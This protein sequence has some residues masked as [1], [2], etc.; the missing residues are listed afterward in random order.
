MS[1]LFDEFNKILKKDLFPL[2]EKYF[3]EP[4]NKISDNLNEFLNDPR[5]FITD[6]FSKFS[7]KTDIDISKENE[8]DIE[9]ITD[10]DASFDDEYDDLLKRLTAIEENMIQIEKILMDKN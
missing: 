7:K 3:K 1:E 5:I 9:Y 2:V 8:R 4:N 10:I 6:I